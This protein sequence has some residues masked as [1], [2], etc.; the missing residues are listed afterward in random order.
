MASTIAELNRQAVDAQSS[1]GLDSLRVLP[2]CSCVNELIMQC[3][4]AFTVFYCSVGAR[5]GKLA[6]WE[7][8][9]AREELT[10]GSC[11]KHCRRSQ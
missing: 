1:A 2:K 3:L 8:W 7:V 10:K 5:W 4:N 6:N 11:A 9:V